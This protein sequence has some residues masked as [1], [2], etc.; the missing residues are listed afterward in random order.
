VTAG[1]V[2]GEAAL[3]SGRYAQALPTFGPERRGALAACT[4]RVS[5]R[6]ILLACSQAHPQ[7]LVVLDPSIWRHAPVTVGLQEGALLLFNTALSPA[8]VEEALR[9]GRHAS[10]LPV[11]RCEIRTLDATKIALEALGRPI[12]NTAML[13]ALAE[14]TGL[15]EMADLEAVLQERFGLDGEAN[16][17]AARAGA[18][19]VGAGGGD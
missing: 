4:L 2:L 7:I 6:P 10:A 8:A 5:A 12:S 16:V 11:A 18:A 19:A 14:A 9:S 13:G 3:R 1:E 17:E 15:V